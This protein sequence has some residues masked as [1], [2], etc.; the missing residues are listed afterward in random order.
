M[1]KRTPHVE[2]YYALLEVRQNASTEVITAAYRVLMKRFH[3]DA[4]NGDTNIAK[5]LNEA[6]AI[7]SDPTKRS[8]YDHGRG[9]IAGT[10]IGEFRVIREIA[11][12]GFGTTYEGEHVLVGEPVCIKHCSGN[13]LACC[14]KREVLSCY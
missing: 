12:G 2:D 5:R 3:P 13:R 1:Q 6:Y 10:V 14:R 11:E 7:L 8:S 9:S 4:K